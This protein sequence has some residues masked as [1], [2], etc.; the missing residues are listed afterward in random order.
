MSTR[1]TR[2]QLDSAAE[3]LNELT[4][5]PQ[6]CYIDRIAQVGNYNISGA[7]GGYS[8]HRIVNTS[9]GVRDV[10]GCGHIKAS[11]LIRLIYAYRNGFNDATS[12]N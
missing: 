12:T 4:N 8:L 6:E 9:G 5:S 7:Y 11:E 10:F 1:I 2:K 3:G